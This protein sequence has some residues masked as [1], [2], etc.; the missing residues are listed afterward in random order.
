MVAFKRGHGPTDS[1]NVKNFLT[2]GGPISFS[3][4][5]LPDPSSLS[6]NETVRC[7]YI[8]GIKRSGTSGGHKFINKQ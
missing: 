7:V 4:G 5:S 8:I 6:D 3:R 2:I 1:I